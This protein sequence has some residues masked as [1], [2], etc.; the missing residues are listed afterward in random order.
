MEIWKGRYVLGLEFGTESVRA[1]LADSADD[2]EAA[3]A[4]VPYRHGVKT[5][6]LPGEKEPLPQDF[7]LQHPGDYIDACAGAISEVAEV[8]SPDDVAVSESILQ[9]APSGR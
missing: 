3:E 9:R 8:I 4:V 1:L 7:A 2:R 5:E 6:K